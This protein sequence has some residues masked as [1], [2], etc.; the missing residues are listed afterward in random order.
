MIYCAC[1]IKPSSGFWLTKKKINIFP[2]TIYTCCNCQVRR[3]RFQFLQL[4]SWQSP[5][6]LTFPWRQRLAFALCAYVPSL[7]YFKILMFPKS[8]VNVLLFWR[9]R[10]KSCVSILRCLGVTGSTDLWASPDLAP[11][12]FSGP[13]QDRVMLATWDYNVNLESRAIPR[14]LT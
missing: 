13:W 5:S 1:H 6:S 2:Q 12:M 7:Y 11:Y 3:V 9:H 8:C 10:A 14:S 4:F